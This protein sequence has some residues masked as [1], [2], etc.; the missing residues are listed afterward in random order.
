MPAPSL[1]TFMTCHDPGMANQMAER[2]TAAGLFCLVRDDRNRFD[3]SFAFNQIEPAVTLELYGKDFRKAERIL[4]TFYEHRLDS[5]ESDY[6]LFSFTDDELLDIIARPDEWGRMDYILAQKILADRDHPLDAATLEKMRSDR[7]AVLAQPEPTR[8]EWIVLGYVLALAGG[9][10]GFITGGILAT[11][12]K[13]LPDGTR[14]FVYSSRDRRS[15]RRIFAL[16]WVG[17]ILY[18]AL[19]LSVLKY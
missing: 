4:E 11:Q 6:Y 8:R 12:K 15:G 10:F 17:I 2:L 1:L 5:V 9:V 13:T 18:L 3:V 19:R 14:R 16:S 7:T